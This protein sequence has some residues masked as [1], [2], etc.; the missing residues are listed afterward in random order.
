MQTLSNR[1]AHAH[2]CESCTYVATL[3]DNESGARDI[4]THNGLIIIRHSC[5]GAD[6]CSMPRELAVQI[7]ARYPRGDYARALHL[8]AATE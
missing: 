1:P 7:A 6:Y 5:R 3:T 4:Y 8:I 2:D